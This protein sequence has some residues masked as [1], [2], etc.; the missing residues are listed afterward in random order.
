MLVSRSSR[1]NLNCESCG[2]DNTVAHA[3]SAAA[4][5]GTATTNDLVKPVNAIAQAV[6]APEGE[7]PVAEAAAVA[8]R[9]VQMSHVEGTVGE[10]N[11]SRRWCGSWGCLLPDFHAGLCTGVNIDS[12]RKRKL[13]VVSS[14]GA[15]IEDDGEK[16][17]DGHIRC[18]RES[19]PKGVG[20][21]G[22]G[23]FAAAHAL[24]C[25]TT[26]TAAAMSAGSMEAGSAKRKP[27]VHGRQRSQ[28]KQCGALQTQHWPFVQELLPQISQIWDV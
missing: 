21:Q 17:A 1:L 3:M 19:V 27:C 24:V 20:E 14:E 23:G 16:Q 25:R 11:M 2:D 18:R 28:C 26:S 8:A 13:A 5:Q 10:A 22:A 12:K 6:T 9:L 7:V 4:H 15:N